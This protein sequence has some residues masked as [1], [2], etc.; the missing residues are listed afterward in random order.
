MYS[1]LVKHFSLKRVFFLYPK[2][3]DRRLR[4]SKEISFDLMMGIENINADIEEVSN[5]LHIL[6][7]F[8]CN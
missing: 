8:F 4:M 3:K 7:E 2:T 1:Y 5:L 6:Q